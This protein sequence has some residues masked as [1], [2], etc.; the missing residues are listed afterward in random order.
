MSEAEGLK[1]FSGMRVPGSSSIRLLESISLNSY[2]MTSTFPEFRKH[3]MLR[4]HG[5]K[6][7]S[8]T[9]LTANQ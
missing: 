5:K 7:L 6:Y 3:G 1:S 4:D 9:G 2:A 8:S